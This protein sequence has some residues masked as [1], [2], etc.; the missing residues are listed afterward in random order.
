M[1]QEEGGNAKSQT[2]TKKLEEFVRTSA[3]S[4]SERIARSLLQ[5]MCDHIY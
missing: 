2:Q 4:H 3:N 1:L 5:L